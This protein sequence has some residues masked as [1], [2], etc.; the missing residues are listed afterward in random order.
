ME[1]G[2]VKEFLASR[3]VMPD[4]SKTHAHF[5]A[6]AANMSS[7]PNQSRDS[8]VKSTTTIFALKSSDF[9]IIAADRQ[10]SYGYYGVF[11]RTSTKITRLTW[12]SMMAMCGMCSTGDSIEEDIKT[13]C[14]TF[15]AL[16]GQSLSVSGQ[17]KYIKRLL[18]NW[19]WIILFFY[20]LAAV[21]ILAAFDQGL[22]QPRIFFFE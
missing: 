19:W 18:Q 2:I 13:M 12:L 8:K 11:S 7:N 3:F 14:G 1:N 21:P 4:Q 22:G 20:E 10:T 17:A 15:E 16:Y 5:Q 6:L 9:A